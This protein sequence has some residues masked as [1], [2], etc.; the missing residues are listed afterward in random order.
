MQALQCLEVLKHKQELG[1]KEGRRA[2]E[3]V[4]ERK[5]ETRRDEEQGEE[6]R[7]ERGEGRRRGVNDMTGGERG[8]RWKDDE[9]F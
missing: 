7:G 3:R 5:D 1:D 9:G 6:G 2:E 4:G 8:R